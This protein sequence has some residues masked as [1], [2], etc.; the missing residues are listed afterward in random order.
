MLRGPTR[1]A[2]FSMEPIKRLLRQR[3]HDWVVTAFPRDPASGIDYDQPTGDPGLFGPDTVTWRVHADFP[4]MLS[5]GLCAL[6]LQTLHPRA[7][8]GVWDHSNFREDLV[9]RLR[10]TTAFVGGTTYA[11]TAAARGLIDKVRRIHDQVSGVTE[12]G[13]PYSANDPELL[14]W[15]HVTEAYSFLRGFRCCTAMAVSPE[16]VD[17]YYDEVRRIAEALGARDVPA[18]AAQVADYLHGVRRQLAV[19]A[20]SRTVLEVL[21][22]IRLPVPAAGLSRELF[23]NAGAA[24]LPPWAED[25]LERSRGQR[26]KA[27]LA[28]GALRTLA[29]LFRQALTN[30]VASRSCRRLGLSPSILQHMPDA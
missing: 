28:S 9:G 27:R 13:Y 18:S 1:F 8:A 10:R 17:R 6:M 19:T 22:H 5:G 30:G 25:M 26:A 16:H 4:G 15:V 24:L 23:L 11:P 29:P 20:R 3:I 12:D 2:V 21:S 7:L 14:T